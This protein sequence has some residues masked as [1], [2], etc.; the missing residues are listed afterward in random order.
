MFSCIPIAEYKISNDQGWI[1]ACIDLADGTAHALGDSS[2][3]SDHVHLERFISVDLH[4][5]MSIPPKISLTH[6]RGGEVVDLWPL[7]LV[8]SNGWS[9]SAL[10]MS[11]NHDL[12]NIR[13]QQL[14]NVLD[15]HQCMTS[16]S[17][18][19]APERVHVT[20]VSGDRTEKRRFTYQFDYGVTSSF[21]FEWSPATEPPWHQVLD[22]E[23]NNDIEFGRSRSS[24]NLH[25]SE[26]PTAASASVMNE[27]DEVNVDLGAATDLSCQLPGGRLGFLS[28]AT[29]R[30]PR[31]LSDDDAEWPHKLVPLENY[32]ILLPVSLASLA[33][34]PPGTALL[35]AG[36]LRE[37]LIVDHHGPY[38]AATTTI[39]TL[40][41]PPSMHSG[42]DSLYQQPASNR[43]QLRGT[44]VSPADLIDE[45]GLLKISYSQSERDECDDMV[46]MNEQ[47]Q[48]I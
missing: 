3:P 1:A 19:Q 45:K 27:M 39:N 20:E 38:R 32:L 4:Q 23:S 5:Y 33:R 17:D 46:R 11:S 7:L 21:S 44:S 40:L 6:V 30:G 24:I 42:V 47:E 36:H 25:D 41:K 29:T 26:I 13:S 9:S 12:Q 15:F 48:E 28:P 14:L 37:I 43:P 34:L 8:G 22:A 31:S 35:H 10:L 2:Y 18:H 16:M